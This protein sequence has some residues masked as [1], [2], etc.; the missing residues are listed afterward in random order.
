MM[1]QYS[2]LIHSIL[3][4]DFYKLTMQCAVVKLF[5]DVMTKYEFIN[6]GHHEFPEGFAAA[7]SEQVHHMSQLALTP[8]EK[9]FL[10]QSCPYLNAAYLDFLS[11][12]RYDP[13]EVIIHQEGTALSVSVHGPW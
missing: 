3:D 2:P 11:G 5:P 12:Y 4:N 10:Q 7:L 8:E 6:R 1:T 9:I 13:R